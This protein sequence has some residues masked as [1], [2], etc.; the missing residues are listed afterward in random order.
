MRILTW[1][2]PALAAALGWSANAAGQATATPPAP[3]VDQAA[4]LREFDAYIPRAMRQWDVPGVAIAVVRNDTVVLAK[5]YGTR[6]L[7][8]SEPVTER[9]IFAI[10]SASKAFTAAAVATLVDEGKLRWDDP[11]T[12]YLPGFQ[13]YDPYVTR[14]LTVRDL[15]S[16][17]SGLTRGDMVW[18][19]G[20]ASDRAEVLRRVRYL[21][22]TWGLRSTFG[23]QNLMYVAAGEVAARITAKSWD[24]VIRVGAEPAE[25]CTRRKN[26]SAASVSRR[27]YSKTS[28]VA[29]CS[30]TARR[31]S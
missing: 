31:N 4:V 25:P 23:Y 10:G 9:T 26:C 3:P 13:L 7:G 14:E 16:H 19:A 1:A 8:K 27:S 22:P 12:Q 24:D 20:V 30:S 18:Y 2:A 28:S 5:G 11:A 17:R 6:T 21:K 15:L 29:P